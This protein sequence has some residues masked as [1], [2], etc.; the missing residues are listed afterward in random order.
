[1]GTNLENPSK[2]GK[3]PKISWRTLKMGVATPKIRDPPPKKKKTHL[4]IRKNAKN[5]ERTRKSFLRRNKREK[6]GG[7]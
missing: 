1:M 6:L 2:S 3:K 4:K 5:Q 7:N